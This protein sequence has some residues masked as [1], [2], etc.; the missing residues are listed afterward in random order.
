MID[1]LNSVIHKSKIF[2]QVYVLCCFPTLLSVAVT[3]VTL[4]LID[5]FPDT[6]TPDQ[7]MTLLCQTSPSNPEAS[8]T[9]RFLTR[10]GKPLALPGQSRRVSR[11]EGP[12]RVTVI[13]QLSV[14][15]DPKYEDVA[16]K[17]EATNERARN[18]SSNELRL[19]VRRE[20]RDSLT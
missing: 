14:P 15:P 10:D 13:S 9:W 19:T 20:Y 4:S 12:G 8:V 11:A 7:L 6:D 17:C 5:H 1:V 3:D 18:V 16:V 2:F